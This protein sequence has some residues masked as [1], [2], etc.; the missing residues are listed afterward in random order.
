[1]FSVIIDPQAAMAAY[2]EGDV[3]GISQTSAGVLPGIK[4]ESLNL[5]TGRLPQLVLSILTWII[6]SCPSFKMLP[7]AGLC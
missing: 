4:T 1:L 2:Q 6:Q 5:H 7:F 3:M